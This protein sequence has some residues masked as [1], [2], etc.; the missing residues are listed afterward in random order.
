MKR[1]FVNIIRECYDTSRTRSGSR[2]FAEFANLF[3]IFFFDFANSRSRTRANAHE[4]S[5]SREFT[6]RGKTSRI[7]EA[8]EHPRIREH[9]RP[10][11]TFTNSRAHPY[12]LPI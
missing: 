7:H 5:R 8:R 1:T 11:R 3:F 9:T 2:M 12:I 10:A 4:Q 6:N